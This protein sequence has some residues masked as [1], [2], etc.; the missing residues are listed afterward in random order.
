MMNNYPIYRDIIINKLQTF[1]HKFLGLFPRHLL[2]GGPGCQCNLFISQM[3]TWAK[4][5]TI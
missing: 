2:M 1:N 4:N 3:F 5:N